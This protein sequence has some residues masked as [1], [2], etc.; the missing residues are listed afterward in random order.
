MF[1]NEAALG[2]EHSITMDDWRLTAPPPGFDSIV[3]RGVT[4]PGELAVT[5]TGMVCGSNS[6][7]VEQGRGSKPVGLQATVQ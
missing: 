3:A 5:S 6:L 4:E 7:W 1:L 2:K